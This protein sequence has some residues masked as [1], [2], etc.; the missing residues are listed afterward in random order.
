MVNG[1]G[2][3]FSP[4]GARQIVIL[5]CC[6]IRPSPSWVLARSAHSATPHSPLGR[7]PQ[8]PAREPVR[9]DAC[10][11]RLDSRARIRSLIALRF[12]F[13]FIFFIYFYNRLC[14]FIKTPLRRCRKKYRHVPQCARKSAQSVPSRAACRIHSCVPTA[15][16]SAGGRAAWQ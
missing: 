3:L 1:K 9:D 2:T 14:F 10:R 12:F 8:T 11:H 7:C 4:L 5:G 16:K 15:E 6:R 13:F